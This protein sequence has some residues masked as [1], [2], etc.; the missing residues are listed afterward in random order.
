MAK[1]TSMAAMTPSVTA[2]AVLKMRET[3]QGAVGVGWRVVPV[4][5]TVGPLWWCRVRV[6]TWSQER[7]TLGP[8][9]YARIGRSFRVSVATVWGGHAVR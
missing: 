5:F 8:E 2:T 7:R 9:G 1:A 3:V 6:L 4:S